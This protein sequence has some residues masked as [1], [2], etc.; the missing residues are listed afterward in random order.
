MRRAV[1]AIIIKDQQ[2]LVMHRNKFGE[3]YDTLPGGN[4]ELGESP[5]QALIREIGEETM[6]KF[7][8]PRLVFLEHAGDPYGDQYIYLCDYQSGEPRLRDDSEE[9][10]INQHGKNL[11][12]PR[13]L[14]LDKLADSIFVSE[15]LKQAILDSLADGWPSKPL[16]IYG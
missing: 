13:W 6:L 12:E 8:N 2:L 1:R 11:H 16:E 15:K 14:A 4:I 10:L 9:N 5:E 3:E 7:A